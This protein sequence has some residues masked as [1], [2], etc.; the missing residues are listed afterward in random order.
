[1]FNRAYLGENKQRVEC[2]RKIQEREVSIG[3]QI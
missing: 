3:L 2:L 1:M